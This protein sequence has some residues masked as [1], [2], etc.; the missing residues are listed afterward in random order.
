M[1]FCPFCANVL[2]L[3]TNNQKNRLTCNLCPVFFPIKEV[4]SARNYCKL[5]VIDDIN[6]K[7]SFENLE[8]TAICCP[9]CNHQ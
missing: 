6:N 1:S 2:F 5:K 7:G 3:E 4:N 9:S 8:S